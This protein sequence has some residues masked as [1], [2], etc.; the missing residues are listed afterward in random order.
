MA[1]DSEERIAALRA[2]AYRKNR[3]IDE[4]QSGENPD[5][6]ETFNRR[7]DAKRERYVRD[8]FDE[9]IT[10]DEMERRTGPG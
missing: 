2:E 9:S 10:E 5:R 6:I 1:E 4:K 8:N 7:A 3:Q